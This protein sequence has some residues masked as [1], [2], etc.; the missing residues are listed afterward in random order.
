MNKKIRV[1]TSMNAHTFEKDYRK[2]IGPSLTVP[3]QSL[4]LREV[5]ER[6]SRGIPIPTPQNIELYEEEENLATA[7]GYDMRNLDISER[8]ELIQ[9]IRETVKEQKQRERKRK[10]T[11]P[12]PSLEERLKKLE[13]EKTPPQTPQPPQQ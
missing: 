12:P 10:A 3:D 11:P 13:A 1:K 5:I 9:N 7:Q 8:Q 2:I 4:K 6:F